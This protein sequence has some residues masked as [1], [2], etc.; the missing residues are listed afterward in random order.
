METTT[1]TINPRVLELLR[2]TETHQRHTEAL[3]AATGEHFNIFQILG[4]GHLEVTTHS[5]IL[6]ELLNPKGKHGQGATFLRLYLAQ[7]GIVGFDAETA[8]VKKEY[9]VGPKTEKSGGRLDIVLK[10]A[11]GATI[12]IENKI[13]ATDQENQMTRYREFDRNAHL[14]YLTLRGGEPSNLAE[15]E[16]NRIQCRCISYAADILT[17]LTECRKAAACLPN[18]RETISQYIHLIEELTNQSTTILMSRELIEEIIRAPETL[19]AFYT[20]RN[21]ELAVQTE[22]IARLEAKLDGLAKANGL[23]RHGP[24][25]DLHLKNAG[26]YFKTPA[27]EHHNLQIGCIF[28]KGYYGDFCFGFAKQDHEKPC[29]VEAEVLSAFK[30]AFPSLSQQPTPAWPAW[31]YWEEPY[32]DWRQE[33]FEAIQSGQFAEDLKAKIEILA[34]MARLIC[35]NESQTS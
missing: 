31:A 29:A 23:E 11:K 19:R 35:P 3:A 14:L 5:P 32:K 26:F 34:K 28:D 24:L 4:V 22:L 7:F 17:W 16:V 13:F 21:A 12:L 30:E 15:D 6:A 10:D 33:A 20:L 8:V 1:A 27:L 9:Y 18:V 2:F 25:R